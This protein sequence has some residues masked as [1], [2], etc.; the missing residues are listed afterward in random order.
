MN[1]QDIIILGTGI[2]GLAAAHH[3]KKAGQKVLLLDKGRRL[4]GRCA[5]RRAD[6]Y[7]FDHGAQFAT[8]HGPYFQELLRDAKDKHMVA[9]WQLPIKDKSGKNQPNTNKQVFIGTPS[10][11]SLAEYLVEG[12]DYQQ[13]VE[14]ADIQ[15]LHNEIK[16]RDSKGQDYYCQHLICSAPAP[17][18]EKLLASAAPD[19]S[20]LAQTAAYDPC[21]TV[22]LGWAEARHPA[23]P[24]SA[25]K[26]LAQPCASLDMAVPQFT[27]HKTS[28]K[29]GAETSHIA[30][31]L[32]AS[33][34]WSTT[35]LE[36]D[37]AIV[38]EAL[39]KA[40]RDHLD[41]ELPAA[42][43]A[44]AH[45]WRYARVRQ[46]A[47]GD[48]KTAICSDGRIVVAGDWMAGPRLEAAFDSG[49][50]A[51]NQLLAQLS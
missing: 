42:D 1:K 27:R 9:N 17:Q 36:N 48:A 19:L 14:I 3:L 49:I 7:V 11:R 37:K 50:A 13:S 39:T 18:T 21:W 44:A 31:V 45:R 28:D 32:Q 16:L 22:M 29:I 20:M 24:E 8:A 4:G 10:M 51:A 46:A 15:K 34:A 38:I 26:L 2:A 25:L 30:L 23:L 41:H 43:Y 5:T 6:G 33:P 47:G 40:Y 35:H 12:L